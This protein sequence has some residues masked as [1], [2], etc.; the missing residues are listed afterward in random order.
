MELK[1]GIIGLPNVGKSSLFNSLTNLNIE[2]K[3]FPFCTIQPNIGIIPVPDN[4]LQKLKDIV[5]S[6]K[7]IHSTI[8]FV[9]IAGLVKGAHKGEGLGNQFLHN[10]RETT[11]IIHVVRCFNDRKITHITGDVNP[12]EDIKIVNTELIYSDFEICELA[13]NQIQKKNRNKKNI[14]NLELITL[15]KCLKHLI[16]NSPLRILNLSADEKNIISRWNFLTL[17]PVIYLANISEDNQKNSDYYQKVLCFI[18][19]EN[20]K[21]LKLCIKKE[22]DLMQFNSKEYKKLSQSFDTQRSSLDKIIQASYKMLNLHTYFTVGKKE[23]HSWTVPIGTNALEAS[24][25]IHSDFKKGFI[26]AQ[27]IAYQDF[28]LYKSENKI[29]SLGKMKLEGKKY[30]IKDGDIVRFLFNI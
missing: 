25:K 23:I 11:A 18:E 1:V 5:N 26:R 20:S 4:R 2:A 13:I 8:K 24:G 6:K 19:K 17:K 21:I 9:D 15:D 10:I 3:N 28:I 7:V 27:I 29:K 22:S 14:S 16:K 12:I 30:I